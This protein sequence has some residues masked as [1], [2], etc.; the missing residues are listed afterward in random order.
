MLAPTSPQDRSLQQ[1]PATPAMLR[2]ATLLQSHGDR[3]LYFVGTIGTLRVAGW[4]WRMA[5]AEAGGRAWQITRRGIWPASGQ[6]ADAA[7][8]VIGEFGASRSHR[9]ATL[10]W[11]DHALEL[12]IDGPWRYRVVLV[13]GDRSLA[14]IDATRGKRF[15]TIAAADADDT[16]PGLLLFVIYVVHA[17]AQRYRAPGRNRTRVRHRTWLVRQT[18]P[19]PTARAPGRAAHRHR[20][21]S[22]TGRRAGRLITLSQAAEGCG[23]PRNPT[24]APSSSAHSAIGRRNVS[25]QT[26]SDYVCSEQ[27]RS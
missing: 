4:T 24:L 2:R 10:R 22:P 6:A 13:D 5:T 25:S 18:A 14:T 1:A 12:R 15:L 9:G 7:G 23:R 16:D 21:R 19:R 26:E 27:R 17:L 3:H 20:R 8:D 11:S